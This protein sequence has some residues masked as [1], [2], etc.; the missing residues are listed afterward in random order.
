MTDRYPH[1]E[2]TDPV[3]LANRILDRPYEDPDSDIAILARQFLRAREIIDR[4][5][6]DVEMLVQHRDEFMVRNEH[7][8]KLLSDILLHAQ[9]PDVMLE[10]GRT[11][12]FVD[13]DPARTLRS[14]QDA[15]ERAKSAIA[16]TER[17]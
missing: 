14:L 15:I 10:D 6:Q 2:L 9:P 7:L 1:G 13:P 5:R 4:Y 8:A 17:T 12:R 3:A 16:K 11:M